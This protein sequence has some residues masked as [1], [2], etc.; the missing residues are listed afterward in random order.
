MVKLCCAW[1]RRMR[2]SSSGKAT[3]KTQWTEFLK[4]QWLCVDVKSKSASEDKTE[5]TVDAN[6][7]E[8][9]ASISFIV[10]RLRQ[11]HLDGGAQAFVCWTRVYVC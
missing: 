5:F 10:D 2:L 6:A 1:P 8:D 7:L 9:D 11:I 4:L 3:S